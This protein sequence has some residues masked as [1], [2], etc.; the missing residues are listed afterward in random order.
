MFDNEHPINNADRWSKRVSWSDLFASVA[1]AFFMPVAIN[2][3]F[4]LLRV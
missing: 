4:A 3:F 2:S 1:L